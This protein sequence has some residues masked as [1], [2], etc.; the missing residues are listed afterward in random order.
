MRMTC[1]PTPVGKL[2]EKDG[3]VVLRALLS[4]QVND[5]LRPTLDMEG[6][7]SRASFGG[8]PLQGFD[9]AAARNTQGFSDASA[10]TWRSAANK[11]CASSPYGNLTPEMSL[12]NKPREHGW[13]FGEV[14][15]KLENISVLMIIPFST[16]PSSHRG[17]VNRRPTGRPVSFLHHV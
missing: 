5:T 14:S 7:Q 4:C 15:K 10:M 17:A 9:K 8:E 1:P 16:H 3:L 11:I 2:S 12:P 6:S 13:A